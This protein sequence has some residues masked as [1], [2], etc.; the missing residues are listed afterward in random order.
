MPDI[1]PIVLP[2]IARSKQAINRPGLPDAFW[3]IDHGP[4]ILALF[5]ELAF[6][7]TELSDEDFASLPLGYQL[8]AHLFSWEAECEADGWGAFGNIDEVAFEA[9]CACFCAIGL[10]AEAESLQVQMAAYLRDPSDAEALDASIRT[11]RHKQSGRLSPI[12]FATQ[13]LCDHA[14]QLLYLPDCSAT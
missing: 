3:E 11:S 6:E 14:Q 9:L 12:Q 5:M 13:Y 2:L 7:L 10:P 8:V 4:T 1:P